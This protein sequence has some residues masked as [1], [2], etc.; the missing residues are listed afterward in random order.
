LTAWSCPCMRPARCRLWWT[1]ASRHTAARALLSLLFSFAF[2][3]WLFD[4]ILMQISNPNCLNSVIQSCKWFIGLQSK[5]SHFCEWSITDQEFG[6]QNLACGRPFPL[7]ELN[8][9]S[10]VNVSEAETQLVYLS[11]D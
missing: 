9:V 4:P 6:P 8:G 5:D 7:G 3:G 1:A 2:L 11:L 10:S